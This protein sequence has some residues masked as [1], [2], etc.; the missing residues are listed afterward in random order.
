MPGEWRRRESTTELVWLLFCN[1]SPTYPQA[2]LTLLSVIVT[3]SPRYVAGFRQMREAELK[4][5]SGGAQTNITFERSGHARQRRSPAL[6]SIL[7][8]TILDPIPAISSKF[9]T[10]NPTQLAVLHHH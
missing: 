2:I 8:R 10:T 1:S 7:G 4:T 9:E 3:L 5:M 6:V